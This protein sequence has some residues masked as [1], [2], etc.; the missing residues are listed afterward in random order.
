MPKLGV[1]PNFSKINEEIPTKFRGTIGEVSVDLHAKNNENLSRKKIS[2]RETKKFRFL[3]L[4][5][6]PEVEIL[7]TMGGFVAPIE[8]YKTV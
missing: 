5:P 7:E 4:T 1:F 6:K 3:G 8:P 2:G